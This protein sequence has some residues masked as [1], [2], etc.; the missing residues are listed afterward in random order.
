M[1]RTNKIIL[2]IKSTLFYVQTC[3]VIEKHILRRH[4]DVMIFKFSANQFQEFCKS[5]VSESM[6]NLILLTLILLTNYADPN[7]ADSNY[8]DFNSAD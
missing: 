7:S 1:R 6:L 8:A 2:E 3:Y 5:N 4:A